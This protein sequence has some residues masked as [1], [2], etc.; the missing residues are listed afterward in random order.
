MA[1]VR[2]QS[3]LAVVCRRIKKGQV[4]LAETFKVHTTTNVACQ[5]DVA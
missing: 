4:Q 5:V 3:M 1:Q 2:L